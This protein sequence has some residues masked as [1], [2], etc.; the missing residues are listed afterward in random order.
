[1]EYKPVSTKDFIV[2]RISAVLGEVTT[3]VDLFCMVN[4]KIYSVKEAHRK[5]TWDMSPGFIHFT[6]MTGIHIENPITF[7]D[8]LLGSSFELLLGLPY[9]FLVILLDATVQKTLKTQ[10]QPLLSAALSLPGER[11]ACGPWQQVWPCPRYI[12]LTPWTKIAW[13]HSGMERSSR[14]A[15]SGKVPHILIQCHSSGIL[16]HLI[17]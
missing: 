7:S 13:I 17:C 3:E 6:K 2:T 8:G 14:L 1:M 11:M 9:F 10:Q 5:R 4:K 12:P 16:C 15:L